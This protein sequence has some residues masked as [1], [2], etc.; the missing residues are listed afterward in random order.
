MR[1]ESMLY[2][3]LRQAVDPTDMGE[4]PCGVCDTPFEVDAVQVQADLECVMQPVC[5]A[6]IE[7][8]GQRNPALYPTIEEFEEAKRCYPEPMFDYEPD[9]HVWVPA[10]SRSWISRK[11][12]ELVSDE[13]RGK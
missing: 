8:L 9:D 3:Y 1:G 12:L 5:P 11:T 13:D 6:C 2:L 7:Y 10:T 4:F